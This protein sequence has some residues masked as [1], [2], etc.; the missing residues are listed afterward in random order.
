MGTVPTPLAKALPLDKGEDYVVNDAAHSL[1]VHLPLPLQ[2]TLKD[3]TH[4]DLVGQD[5]ET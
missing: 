4:E 5:E 2:Q 1:E 3:L